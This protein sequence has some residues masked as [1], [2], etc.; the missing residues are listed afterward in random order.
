MLAIEKEG[1]WVDQK[2]MI[3]RSMNLIVDCIGRQPTILIYIPVNAAG[4]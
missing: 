4:Q 3:V 2:M 1:R